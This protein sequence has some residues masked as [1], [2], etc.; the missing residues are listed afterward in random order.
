MKKIIK[1]LVLIFLISF[2]GF[3]IW[4]LKSPYKKVLIMNAIPP[5]PVVIIE[6]HDSYKT[7]KKLTQSQVWSQLKKHDFFSRIA[8]GMDMMDTVINGNEKLAKFIGSH[9]LVIS[10]HVIRK[11]VYDFVYAFDSRRLSKVLSAKDLFKGFLEA[12][13]NIETTIHHGTTIYK[14]YDKTSHQYL[15]ICLVPARNIRPV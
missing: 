10:M 9:D 3:V 12:R 5:K 15:N 11:G 14:V 1:W 4:E 8:S 2:I 6:T 13:F 7:W